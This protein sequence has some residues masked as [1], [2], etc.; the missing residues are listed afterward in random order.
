MKM[1]QLG[2]ELFHADRAEVHVDVTN[3]IVPFP[4]FANA[5]KSVYKLI[6]GFLPYV[7]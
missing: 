6:G 3:L 2:A 5:P 7:A 4:N 1:R